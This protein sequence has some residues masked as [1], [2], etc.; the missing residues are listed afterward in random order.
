MIINIKCVLKDV[1]DPLGSK[2]S[3]DTLCLFLN[4]YDPRGGDFA[5]PTHFKNCTH[6][7]K[8]LTLLVHLTVLFCV[9]IKCLRTEAK[10]ILVQF[11]CHPVW[12]NSKAQ[13]NDYH[14]SE[15]GQGSTDYIIML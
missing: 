11:C 15:I 8:I 4:P 6:G 2:L 5:P 13:Y 3:G 7:S 9:E 12:P 14:L 1:S 10:S